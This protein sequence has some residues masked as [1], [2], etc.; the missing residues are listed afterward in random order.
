MDAD[1][2]SQGI[3][4]ARAFRV[5]AFHIPIKAPES[6]LVICFEGSQLLDAERVELPPD[7]LP[8]IAEAVAF[9]AGRADRLALV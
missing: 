4:G 1:V 8:C 7:F 3:L 2:L 6:C 9:P 5:Q